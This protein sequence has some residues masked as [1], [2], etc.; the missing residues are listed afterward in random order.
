MQGGGTPGTTIENYGL[1]NVQDDSTINHNDGGD[2]IAFN[3]YGTFLKS[4]GATNNSTLLRGGLNFTN[5]G[6]MDVASGSVLL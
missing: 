1:W 5:T 3:N 6:T 2:A 4:A